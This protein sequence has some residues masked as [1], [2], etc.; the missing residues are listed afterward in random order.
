VQFG[1]A[2]ETLAVDSP[3]SSR[4]LLAGFGRWTSGALGAFESFGVAEVVALVAVLVAAVPGVDW[5]D[6]R[7]F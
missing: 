6:G 4:A 1:L 3:P 2:C 5:L 7:C